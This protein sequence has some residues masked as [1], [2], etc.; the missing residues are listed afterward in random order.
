MS[1]ENPSQL[2]KM[3][4]EGVESNT[5]E[6]IKQD[7]ILIITIKINSLLLL[8]KKLLKNLN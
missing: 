1:K 8:Q 3:L 2:E 6:S 4:L 7:K 5:P